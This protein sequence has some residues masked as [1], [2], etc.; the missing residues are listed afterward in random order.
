M[1]GTPNMLMILSIP[2]EGENSAQRGKASLTFLLA[3]AL[4]F[5]GILVPGP[6]R[7]TTQPS[8]QRRQVMRAERMVAGT[9]EWIGAVAE[10]ITALSIGAVIWQISEQRRAARRE[11]ARGFQERYQSDTFDTSAR[12]MIGCMEVMDAEDCIDVIR[13]CSN[14]PDA[15]ARVLPWPDAPSK[16]SVQDVDKTLNLFEE[17]GAAYKLGQ[18]DRKTLLQSFSFPTIQ[19]FVKA[20]WWICWERD[21][22][23]AR[24]AE[25]GVTEETYVEYQDMVLA[26][27]KENPSLARHGELQPNER[28]RALCLPKGSKGRVDDDEAWAASRRLS[29]SLSDFVREAEGHGVVDRLSRLASALDSLPRSPDSSC[30]TRPGGWRVILVPGSIDRRP[31]GEW[32]RQWRAAAKLGEAL[33]RFPDYPSLEKAIAHVENGAVARGSSSDEP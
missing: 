4:C 24:Q 1:V 14:R 29:L 25:N 22:R 31:S 16:A 15:A 33:D 27:R 13:E 8:K 9:A 28:V 3:L 5:S 18:M 23:L 32:E 7:A 26:L 10:A 11:R 20:W 30:V 2:G 19:V 6:A 21:G 12:R 17:M